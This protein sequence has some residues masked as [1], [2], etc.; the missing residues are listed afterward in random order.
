MPLRDRACGLTEANALGASARPNTRLPNTGPCQR[1]LELALAGSLEPVLG[2]GQ[3]VLGVPLGERDTG[4]GHGG[5]VTMLGGPLD[6]LGAVGS[7][8][9]IVPVGGP[10]APG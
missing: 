7:L 8:P 5:G 6:A 9:G 1:T 3:A 2:L 10:G 4:V